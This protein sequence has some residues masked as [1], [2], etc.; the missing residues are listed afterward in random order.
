[1]CILLISNDYVSSSYFAAND[2]KYEKN[3]KTYTAAYS[4]KTSA[5]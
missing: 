5:D 2:K 1:M 4:K 3:E